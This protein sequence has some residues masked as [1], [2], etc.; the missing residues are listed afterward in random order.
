LLADTLEILVAISGV[1][2]FLH[3][4]PRLNSLEGLAKIFFSTVILG[5]L[6][7]FTHGMNGL[8]ETVGSA[9]GMSFLSEALAFLTIT[10][11]ILGWAGHIRA[12]VR[13]HAAITS[14]PPLCSGPSLR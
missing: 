4:L 9:G 3:G 10:P 14:K 6:V 8:T 2:Y 7:V 13:R 12:K 1:S 5:R 11:S